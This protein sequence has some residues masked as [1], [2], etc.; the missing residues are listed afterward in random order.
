MRASSGDVWQ[1]ERGAAPAGGARN[2][3]PGRLRDPA[4]AALR[5]RREELAGLG[6]AFGPES[7]KRG[8]EAEPSPDGR[9]REPQWSA[10]RRARRSQDARRASQSAEVRAP[11]GAPLPH[12]HR[13][14]GN[15]GVPGALQTI[16]AAER[17]LTRTSRARRST[18]CILP[19]F[20]R[21]PTKA[22]A[23]SGTLLKN[24]RSSA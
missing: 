2:P 22:A 14:S 17:W 6:R 11:R 7:R 5:P 9:W 10:A 18:E 4:R 20:V 21:R 19:N 16:R 23:Y 12:V 15:E 3:A 8:P 1:I 24:A 13:G